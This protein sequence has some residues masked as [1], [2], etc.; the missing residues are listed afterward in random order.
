[1]P[2]IPYPNVPNL[3]GV[4]AL[5]RSNNAQFV[6]AGLTIL[7]EIL[8]LGLFGQKWGIVANGGSAALTPDS[9]IDF[10][11]REEA[12]IPIY[13]LQNGAF[14]SYNKV[15]LPYDIRLTVTCSGNGKMSKG[16]FI[17]GIDKLLTSLT[18]VD[19]VTP[20]ATYKNTNL[21]HVDYRREATNGATLLIAQLWFQWVRIVSNPT[22]PTAQPSG[23]PSSSFGQLSPTS[24]PSGN[25]GSLN[26]N[27]R[28][29][30]GLNPAIL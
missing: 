15:G 6:A 4:P 17:Q 2:N 23:T 7:G 18:L 22:V 26:A 8:P 25:F 29:A 27:S 10:E 1:M 30:T 19:I 3:P 24:V 9:F 28:G 12:K 13:P 20:D 5:S 14:Q 16:A 21:I 11:Y